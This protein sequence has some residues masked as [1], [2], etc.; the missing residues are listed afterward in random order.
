MGSG[1]ARIRAKALLPKQ[2]GA[3]TLSEDWVNCDLK[4]RKEV[5]N[6][7]QMT[8]VKSLSKVRRAAPQAWLQKKSPTQKVMIKKPSLPKNWKVTS[9]D[10]Y[11]K[12]IRRNSKGTFTLTLTLTLTLEFRLRAWG[13]ELL[14]P[15]IKGI[16]NFYSGSERRKPTNSSHHDLLTT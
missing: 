14:N 1:L 8:T 16:T 11:K 13:R 9:K 12:K 4:S 7:K 3:M 15:E 5:Q 2:T 10:S 6:Y